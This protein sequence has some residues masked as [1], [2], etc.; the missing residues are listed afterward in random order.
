MWDLRGESAT[1]RKDAAAGQAHILRAG[2]AE[3]RARDI[4]R[5]ESDVS[6]VDYACDVILYSEFKSMDAQEQYA[7]HPV[8]LQA[9]TE[10]QG[11]RIAS[12]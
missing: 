9:R 4:L 1:E 5:S 6:R 12:S 7:H 10:L 3:S 8:H 2:A 11:V